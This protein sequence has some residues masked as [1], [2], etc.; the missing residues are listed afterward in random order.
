[1]S[2]G[3]LGSVASS[4]AP[5]TGSSSSAA[6]SNNEA[7]M[8]SPPVSPPSSPPVY[9]STL[10]SASPSSHSSP[11]PPPALSVMEPYSCNPMAAALANE[12]TRNP[13]S[14]L[15]EFCQIQKLE[16]S[17]PIVSEHGP[18]HFKSFTIAASCPPFYAEAKAS[19][20]KDAKRMAADLALQ[21]IRACIVV[22]REE[23]GGPAWFVDSTP[24]RGYTDER[25]EAEQ[26]M[27]EGPTLHDHIDGIAHSLHTRLEL[28]LGS[29]Q[30]GR[31]VIACF[32]MEDAS[33]KQL[34][35]IS[36]GSGTRTVSGDVIDRNGEVVNDSHAEII[37]RRGLKRFFYQ[38][39]RVYYEDG[40]SVDTIFEPIEGGDG[41]KVRV[42]DS[43]KFHLYISTAPCGDGAQFSRQDS[44]NRLP[45]PQGSPHCPTKDA[46]AQGILRTKMEGGEGTIPIGTDAN[47]QTWDG[48]LQG[49][50]LRTMSCSDKIGSWNVLGLQ[51]SLLSVFMEPVYLFSLTLGSL[52]HH[53]HLSRAV[54]CRFHELGQSLRPPYTVNHPVLGRVRGGDEMKRHTE[55]TS[56]LSMNWVINDAAPELTDGGTGR[57][58][59][60]SSSSSQLSRLNIFAQ[61]RS[62]CELTGRTNYLNI[63]SYFEAKGLA[64]DYQEMKGLLY[65]YCIEKGY[66]LWMSKPLEM[67]QF[68]HSEVPMD[69]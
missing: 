2:V 57:P 61:F 8:S 4:E 68:S 65:R 12:L 45:P 66:G 13:V 6:Q 21:R 26:E 63:E 59:S 55:R 28:A 67:N 47:P 27:E 9:S 40:E 5:P 44:Q 30:P 10:P 62:L 39:L 43:I 37:A 34:E 20:K 18:P 49:G 58:V 19:T 60:S 1:M 25:Y 16:L 11:P 50:R 7:V 24:T 29:P 48:I 56:N 64:G 46:R 32:I 42:K 3:G 38:E 53:G 54:C 31:K 41:S 51:G 22:S 17:F 33:T 35:V 69:V 52:H 23:R 36:F 15:S 14:V